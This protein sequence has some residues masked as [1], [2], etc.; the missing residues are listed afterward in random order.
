MSPD[1]AEHV[2]HSHS[3]LNCVKDTDTQCHL[4]MT[5]VREGALALGSLDAEQEDPQPSDVS[6]S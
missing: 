6:G 2:T 1:T 5:A 3:T 4:R